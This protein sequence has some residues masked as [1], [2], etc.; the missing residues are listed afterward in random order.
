MKV[1]FVK[2]D[3]PPRSSQ[4]IGSAEVKIEFDNGDTILISNL[5]VYRNRQGNLWIGYPHFAFNGRYVPI[6]LASNRIQRALEDA[7]F[8]HVEDFEATQRNT[9]SAEARRG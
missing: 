3:P 5:K 7:I 9:V 6:F 8:P 2:L 1:E 4:A